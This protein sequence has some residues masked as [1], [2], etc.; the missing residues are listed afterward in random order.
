MSL[1]LRFPAASA[2]ACQL[3]SFTPSLF[4]H[5]CAVCQDGCWCCLIHT[6]IYF[7]S[8]RLKSH[9]ESVNVQVLLIMQKVKFCHLVVTTGDAVASRCEKWS[10]CV[11]YCWD[12]LLWAYFVCTSAQWSGIQV[13]V[14]LRARQCL[15]PPSSIVNGQQSSWCCSVAPVNW[16]RTWMSKVQMRT[17]TVDWFVLDRLDLPKWRLDRYK[18]PFEAGVRWR[19]VMQLTACVIVKVLKMFPSFLHL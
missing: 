3:F 9:H 1:L 2:S 11:F 14:K 7:S 10:G 17:V 15:T 19:K 12:L 6:L 8:W 4:S 13:M 16:W 18:W 5:S